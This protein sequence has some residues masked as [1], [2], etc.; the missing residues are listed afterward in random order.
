[1]NDYDNNNKKVNF[2]YI[3]KRSALP[4]WITTQSLIFSAFS[5]FFTHASNVSNRLSLTNLTSRFT[6]SLSEE[7]VEAP[8]KNRFLAWAMGFLSSSSDLIS[9][10]EISSS[11]TISSSESLSEKSRHWKKLLYIFEKKNFFFQ[12]IYTCAQKFY[13]QYVMWLTF[14]RGRSCI[15]ICYMWNWNSHGLCFHIKHN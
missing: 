7:S 2:I 8:I 9:S 10:L 5:I 1:M 15:Y 14:K 4:F 11:E 13:T 12:L 6:S 3:R